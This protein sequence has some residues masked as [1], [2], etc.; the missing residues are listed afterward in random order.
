VIARALAILSAVFL[1]GSVA[2]ATLGP[3]ELPLGQALFL[4][5]HSFMDTLQETLEQHLP[6]W[7]WTGVVVPL[8]LRPVWLIPVSLGLV[9]GGCALSLPSRKQVR[10]SQRRF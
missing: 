10:R 4:L 5:D 2:L 7:L 1:V 6:D 3:P 9:C 8:L